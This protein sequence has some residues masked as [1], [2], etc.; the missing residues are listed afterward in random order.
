MAV[1]CVPR[2]LPRRGP[3]A[4]RESSC[5]YDGVL[6]RRLFCLID[7]FDR[8]TLDFLGYGFQLGIRGENAQQGLRSDHPDLGLA[9][10]LIHGDAARQRHIQRHV[11]IEDVDGLSRIADLK[12]SAFI[13]K[14]DALALEGLLEI[15]DVKD[16]EFVPLDGFLEVPRSGV[17][18]LGRTRR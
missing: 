5:R 6:R 2:A 15:V 9:G 10:V 11:M 3:F 4:K 14:L 12:N 8:F 17:D 1:S 16:S 18:R 7:H 13:G